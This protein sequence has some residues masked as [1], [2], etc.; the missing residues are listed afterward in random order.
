MCLTLFHKSHMHDFTDSSQ[1]SHE[2]DFIII[3]ILKMKLRLREVEQLAQGHTA[4]MWQT[5]AV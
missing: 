5:Q 4:S 2:A 1:E 3:L